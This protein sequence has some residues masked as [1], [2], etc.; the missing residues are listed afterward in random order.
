MK[1]F[2]PIFCTYFKNIVKFR[3]D[4]EIYEEYTAFCVKDGAF[5]FRIDDGEEII[6]SAGEVAVCPPNH[7]F[8]RKIVDPCQMC[9]IKFNMDDVNLPFGKIEIGNVLRFND[10]MKKLENCL[11]CNNLTNEPF[12]F[13]YCLDILYL[14]TENGNYNGK[15]ATAK[16]YME[17]CY[18][19]NILI[20]KAA[21]Q[22]GYTTPHFINVFK[23][24][25]GITPKAYI[26]DIKLRKA[27]EMLITTDMLSREIAFSL[28]F[29]DELYFS[30]FFKKHS[31]M[32][33][34]Q[35]KRLYGM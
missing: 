31:G 35:F 3:Y 23:K 17:Q 24:C 16:K 22:A 9:M 13:H 1:T 19:K 5:S 20:D 33:P 26:A 34:R 7:R 30:R 8:Y 4:C 2:S 14:A 6:V 28:G 11:F 32:T 25:Y 12:F 21:E 15:L 29:E 18:N 10:N 27:K